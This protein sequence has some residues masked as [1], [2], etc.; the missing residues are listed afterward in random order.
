MKFEIIKLMDIDDNVSGYMVYDGRVH[1]Y[2]KS[3]EELFKV[4]EKLIDD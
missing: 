3:K 4:I 1:Y 2:R